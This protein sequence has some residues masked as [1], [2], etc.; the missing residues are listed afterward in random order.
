MIGNWQ[1]KRGKRN[2]SKAA[3]FL[4]QHYLSNISIQSWC[5]FLQAPW[6]QLHVCSSESKHIKQEFSEGVLGNTGL[7]LDS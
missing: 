2:I 7:V 3:S 5:V 1:A 6:D 4:F